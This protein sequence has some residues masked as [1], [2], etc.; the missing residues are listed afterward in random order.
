M[1]LSLS[2]R[3]SPP[4]TITI[5]DA[6]PS[7]PLKLI[8]TIQQTS[9]PYPDRAVTILS[10]YTCLEEATPNGEGAF[11]SNA[12]ASPQLTIDDGQG[13]APLLPL[14]PVGK[15]ITL[16]RLSGDPDLLKR[17]DDPS[18]KFLT[19]PPVGEGHAEVMWELPPQKLLQRLGH[20]DES[21]EDKMKR[22]LRRGDTYK[23]V[24]RKESIA[25]WTFGSLEGEDGLMT[26]KFARWS[27][28]DDLPLVR[29]P[30]TEETDEMAHRLR[31]W[32]DLHNVNKLSSRSAI[33]D[34]QIPDIGEMRSEGWVFGEPNAGLRLTTENKEQGAQ[35]TIV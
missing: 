3:T 34:E 26:K 28:P 12:M 20:E 30:G 4:H 29:S 7:E 35:F 17:K 13:L 31:D 9:S 10:K 24:P 22:L 2:L 5:D 21:L 32:V 27:L 14:R 16:I 6:S 23:I 25:W 11:F 19:I 1:H 8:A 18:F 33:E 15:R